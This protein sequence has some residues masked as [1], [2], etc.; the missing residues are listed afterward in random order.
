MMRYFLGVDVGNTKCHALISDETGQAVGFGAGGPGNHENLGVEGATTALHTVVNKAIAQANIS[1]K[2]IAGAGFGLAGHDWPSDRPLMDQIINTLGMNAPHDAVNDAM[3]GL[4]AGAKQGWGVSVS[5]GTSSNARG[6]DQHGNI[7]RMTGNGVFFGELG[8]GVELVYKAVA[9]ISR[10]WSKRGPAT[11]LSTTLI[12][13]VGAKNVEDF[14]E[15]LARGRY[16]VKA[17]DAPIIFEAARDGD[18]V[19]QDAI[20]WIGQGLGDLAVGIIHQLHFEEL[21]FE[22]V[23]AGSLYNGSPLFA[24]AMRP[25]IQAVAPGAT[26]VRLDAPP[27]VGATM[28]GLDEL[29]HD[30]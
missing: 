23:L 2:D 1:I 16:R 25:I 12:D 28:L 29:Y 20:T 8:G 27:V 14:L 13:H 18:A 4:I 26:L 19:A 6:R 5:A 24:E 15:G 30:V 17:T 9:V 21:D 11:I 7:G 10:E 22:V 3:N